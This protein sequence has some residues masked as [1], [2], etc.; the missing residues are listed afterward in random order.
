[1]RKKNAQFTRFNSQLFV[2]SSLF[3]AIEPGPTKQFLLENRLYLVAPIFLNL[4][5]AFFSFRHLKNEKSFEFLS[6]RCFYLLITFTRPILFNKSLCDE[7][8]VRKLLILFPVINN[9]F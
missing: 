4:I 9:P 3:S 6:R 7:L 8:V 2:H 1:M 5:V